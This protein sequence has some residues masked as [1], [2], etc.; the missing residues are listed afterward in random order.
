MSATEEVTP[1]VQLIGKCAATHHQALFHVSANQD[2][3]QLET[4]VKVIL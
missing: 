3:L 2:T 4:T 1:V